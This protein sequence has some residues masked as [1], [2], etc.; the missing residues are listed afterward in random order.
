MF[1]M[2]LG[3]KVNSTRRDRVWRP[4]FRPLRYSRYP[5][6]FLIFAGCSTALP[7]IAGAPSTPQVRD[8]PWRAPAGVV[9]A[10]RRP[11]ST[12]TAVADTVRS[13]G[14]LALGQV[15]DMAL[16]NNPQTAVSWA[17]ARVGA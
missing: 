11:D 12:I 5:A 10:E 13:A 7:K 4:E 2:T 14:P 3:M 16:R 8:E 17:Q 1:V 9:P 15:V 6:I